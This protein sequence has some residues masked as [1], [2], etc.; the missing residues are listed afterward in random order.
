M[1]SIDDRLTNN[2]KI[3]LGKAREVQK[4]IEAGDNAKALEALAHVVAGLEHDIEWIRPEQSAQD[5]AK[6]FVKRFLP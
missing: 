4:S 2:L 5:P 1:E 6:P 3:T